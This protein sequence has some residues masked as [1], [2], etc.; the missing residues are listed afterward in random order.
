[1]AYPQ[2][3]VE[4][5]PVPRLPRSGLQRYRGAILDPDSAAGGGRPLQPTAFVHDQI[6]VQ[7]SG[8]SGAV[9]ALVEAAKAT[10][11]DIGTSRSAERKR[12]DYVQQLS[13]AALEQMTKRWVTRFRITP[14]TTSSSSVADAYGTIRKYRELA[15]DDDTLKVGLNH[16]VTLAGVGLQGVPY[17]E[18]PSLAGVPYF[19]GPGLG[20]APYF[21]GPSSGVPYFEGPSSGAPVG[22]RVPVTWLGNP[23]VPRRTS[24]PGRRPVVAVLDTG[25][26]RHG[27]LG[28][29]SVTLGATVNGQPIG[30]GNDVPDSEV[31]GIVL[32]PELGLLDR[33]SG[34][35]TFIAGIIRQTCPDATVLAIRVMPSDGVVEEHQLCIALNKLLVRQAQ[36]QANG[37]LEDVIDVMSL[38]LGYYHEDP[39]DVRYSSVLAGTLRSFAALGVTVVTAAGN[40]HTSTPFFP[41]G[42]A[43]REKGLD[44]PADRVPLV[45]VGALNPNASRALF[46]NSGDWVSCYRPGA[47]VVSTLPTT[48]DGSTQ[49]DIVTPD[50]G[51]SVDRDDFTGGFGVWSGTS[52]AAP[53][54]AGE[55]AANL[56]TQGN[57]DDIAPASMV[58]RGWAALAETIEWKRPSS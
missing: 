40:D 43:S 8:D 10:G 22:G 35:G 32:Q 4:R 48:F 33:D 39:E 24:G 1:M 7:G 29:G 16:L 36:A 34:H 6:L 15:G 49:P 26:G 53:V 37:T 56:F 42:F 30:V 20:G 51:E 45:S 2:R 47:N 5:G 13:G 52:F 27:W 54:L 23:P 31:T 18:G 46:S 50:G 28:D 11:H 3:P 44:Q 14:K 58:E 25:L 21:E 55:L 38:S 9:D 41:A 12:D 57:L 17:F 19:E